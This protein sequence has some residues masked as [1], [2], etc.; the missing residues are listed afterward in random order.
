MAEAGYIQSFVARF[1]EGHQETRALMAAALFECYIHPSREQPSLSH[2]LSQSSSLLVSD[3]RAK[4]ENSLPLLHM[5]KLFPNMSWCCTASTTNEMS[6]S[7]HGFACSNRHTFCLVKADAMMPLLQ[8]LRDTNS[9]V[10]KAALM[11]LETLLEDHNTLSHATAAIVES[12]GVLA[13]LQVLEKGSLSA[14]SKALDLFLKI[15]NHSK[16]SDTSF[17]RAE[18]ILI[19]LLHEDEI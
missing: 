19:Q 11:A 17:Q 18:G 12:Q 16:I 10:A 3:I 8:T 14:K 6:C 5:M 13:I 15:L 9:G 2:K 4:Q 7:I 1:N